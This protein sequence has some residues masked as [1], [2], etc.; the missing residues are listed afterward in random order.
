MNIRWNNIFAMALILAALILAARCGPATKAALGTITSV[1]PHEP[2]D[3]RFVG[4]LVLGLLMVTLVAII[5]MLTR[6]RAHDRR[7]RRDDPPED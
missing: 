3:D 5:K 7:D 4:F 6:G 1:A 2:V